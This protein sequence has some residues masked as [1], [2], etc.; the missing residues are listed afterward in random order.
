MLDRYSLDS[1]KWPMKK[2]AKEKRLKWTLKTV[3]ILCCGSLPP[4]LTARKRTAVGESPTAK[5]SR[6]VWIFRR[7]QQCSSSFSCHQGQAALRWLDLTSGLESKNSYRL[8][9]VADSGLSVDREI[10]ATAICQASCQLATAFQSY[11]KAWIYCACEVLKSCN[12]Q[13]IET[14]RS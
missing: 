2:R 13:P 5:N 7:L 9:R 6:T 14:D 10:W 8:R 11:L 4:P 1:V 12:R 3:D